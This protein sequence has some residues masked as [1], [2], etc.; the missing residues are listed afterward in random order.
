MR[1]AKL[2]T[3]PTPLP[4]PVQAAPASKD[5]IPPLVV[6]KYT[7]SAPDA[8]RPID[9]PASTGPALFNWVPTPLGF[10]LKTPS[11]DTPPFA[12]PMST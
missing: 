9:R 12:T 6:M 2:P 10:T 3:L 8:L 7:F 1:I 4:A 5:W 11:P